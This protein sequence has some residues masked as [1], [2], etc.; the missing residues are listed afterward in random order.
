MASYGLC[1]PRYRSKE[2]ISV[3][4]AI[5]TETGVGMGT[6]LG[7]DGAGFKCL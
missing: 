3:A 1:T 5:D 6:C 2:N 4:V 7:I